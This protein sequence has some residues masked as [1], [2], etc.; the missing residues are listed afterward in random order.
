MNLISGFE[1]GLNAR[2]ALRSG[3]VT[4]KGSTRVHAHPWDGSLLSA[5]D[6]DFFTWL[7]RAMC[8]PDIP[9]WKYLS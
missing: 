9:P 4:L 2:T 8:P 7:R 5:A 6:S 1:P 3:A